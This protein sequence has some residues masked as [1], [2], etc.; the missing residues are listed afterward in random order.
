MRVVLAIYRVVDFL[1]AR[2]CGWHL[3]ELLQI[4]ECL[5]LVFVGAV[6]YHDLESFIVS[7]SVSQHIAAA[8]HTTEVVGLEVDQKSQHQS[9]VV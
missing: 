7:F 3:K 8:V 1:H 6:V 2:R 9:G 4:E 5:K